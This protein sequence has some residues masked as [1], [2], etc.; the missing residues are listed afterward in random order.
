[1][2]HIYRRRP[3]R[4]APLAA[5]VA[6]SALL[7]GT[8]LA[9]PALAAGSSPGGWGGQT[10][11]PDAFSSLSPAETTDGGTWYVAYTTAAGGIDYVIH[12]T[13]WWP[14]VRSVSGKDVTPDTSS[15][16]AI[17]FFQGHLY[18]FWTNG[19]G[20]IR[21]TDLDGTTWKPAQTV[22]GSW[23]TASAAWSPSVTV[24]GTGSS[25]GLWLAWTGNGSNDIYMSLTSGSSWFTP[26]IAVH[27]PTS[28][29]PSIAGLD[30]GD[31]GQAV[32]LAWTDSSNDIEYAAVT[33]SLTEIYGTVPLAG[34]N[35]APSLDIMTAT[36]DETLWVAWKGSNKGKVW[37]SYIPEFTSSA[38]LP[39][40]WVHEATLP[41]AYTSTGPALA[42]SGTSLYAVYK[43]RTSDHMHTET[44]T[45]S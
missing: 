16:P 28:Y 2:N 36:P 21:Y 29:S 3:P 33:T 32:M 35:A 12:T 23:G 40:D 42:N 41:I 27:E 44:N 22:S 39:G 7:A 14:K 11:V 34:T 20:Q 5:T 25:A 45:A 18:V 8:G 15:A 17:T 4:L 19:S 10:M 43:G 31:G 26:F 24:S 9:A 1:M 6:A 37:Y 13:G 30:L 38:P